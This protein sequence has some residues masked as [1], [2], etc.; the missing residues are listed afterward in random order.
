MFG[1]HRTTPDRE[2]AAAVAAFHDRLAS[3]LVRSRTAARRPDARTLRAR[4]G[5]SASIGL[6][7]R[8]DRGL[9]PG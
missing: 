9:T 3:P 2:L 4:L 1:R 5:G 7:E 6:R 8:L